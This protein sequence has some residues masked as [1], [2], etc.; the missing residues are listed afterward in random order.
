MF[1]EKSEATV[2]A[3]KVQELADR[4]GILFNSG[5]GQTWVRVEYQPQMHYAENG[6]ETA[7]IVYPTIVEVLK[8]ELLET[9]ELA[10]EAEQIATI[11]SNVLG[12]PQDNTHI[13][14]LPE[15]A[16]RIAF[17]GKL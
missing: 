16:K 7:R 3:G 8:A 11:V 4:L 1:F 9:R 2:Q 10:S 5:K 14:Y 15:A 12:V 17:G 13:L 6:T